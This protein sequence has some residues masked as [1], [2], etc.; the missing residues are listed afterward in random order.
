ME[1]EMTA[2]GAPDG[3]DAGPDDAT[4]PVR[5]AL[6]TVDPSFYII[7]VGASAGG[8][9]AIKQLIGQAPEG[10]PHS[11]VIIQ[12]IS[13][14]YKS[15]MSEILSRETPLPV[16]EVDDD[17]AVEPGHIYLI[18][19]KSNVV[20]Q[21]TVDDTQPETDKIGTAPALGL[22]F[23]LV[24]PVPRPQLNLPIDLFFH[25][26]AEA[27]GDRAIAI[28]LSGT[29]T[30]GSRGLR[31]IKDRDGFV[32]VQEPATANFDGMPLA[33]IATKIVDL[34]T[35]PD[36][37][38]SELQ[39][40]IAMR[41]DGVINVET[42]FKG[43]DA[44]FRE[45]LA[46]ISD[47][48]DIDFLQYKE[49]TLKR[50]IARR[51]AINHF[52]SVREYLAYARQ[53]PH[54][55]AV[56][57]REFLVGVTN[58]FR[59]LP[60]WSTLREHVIPRLFKEGEQS[61]MVKIWSVG[62]ST[63]EEAYTIAMLMESYRREHDLKRDF[64]V[65]ATDVNAD[66]IRSAK[67]GVYPESVIEE[68][69][70]EFRTADYVSFH[71]GTF[72]IAKAIRS[73]VIFTEHN[74]LEDPPYINTDLITCR[75]LLIYL[76]SD[77]QKK[78]L[79][80]FAFSMRQNGFLFL[81]AAE[82]VARQSSSFETEQGSARIYRNARK[83][84]RGMI[85][86]TV[87]QAHALTMPMPR[88]RRLA[89]RE[90]SRSNAA[91]AGVIR[92]VLDQMNGCVFVIDD[93]G[94]I[95]ETFGD[96][97]AYVGLPE[98][99]FSANIYDLVHNRL[100]SAI[101]LQMRRA[102]TEGTG[103]MK[104]IKCPVE[105][106]IDLIDVHCSRVE[107]EPHP[108]TFTLTLRRSDE[109][110]LR[111][112]DPDGA[113]R[114][115]E[116]PEG[117][118]STIARLESE[119][120][121]LQ[122]MLS[123]TA[124]DL[125]V[126]NEE[127]Q[128]TN[129]ELTVSNE[130]LQANNEE[131]Q[132]INEELHTVNAEN[133]EKIQQLE[134]ANADIENLLDTADLAIV[135]LDDE[136]LIRRY[137]TAFTRYVELTRSDIGRSLS[138]FASNIAAQD[139]PMV[140]D[141]AERARDLGHEERRDIRCK[142]GT[143]AVV[144][145][146]PYKTGDGDIF[147]VVI[148]LMDTTRQQQLQEEVRIQRDRLT[149]LLESEAAGYFDWDIPGNT[150]YLSPRFKEMFG[151][152]DDELPNTPDSWMKI[153]HPDDL[154]RVL[155]QFDEHVRTRGAVPWDNEVRYYH[156][157]GSIVWV[158][159]RGRV[160]EWGP[161]GSALRMLGVHL[162]ITALKEREKTVLRDAEEVRRFAF[163]AAHDLL[164]PMSTIERSLSSLM[165]DLSPALDE[166]QTQIMHYLGQATARMRARIN[167]VLDYARIFDG[168]V[169]FTPVDLTDL[170]QSAIDDLDSQI[171]QIG[172]EITLSPL[173]RAMAKPDLL[174]SV[175]QN[176]L[177]NAMK[178]RHPD[179]ACRIAV[180]PAPAPEGMV[181][182]RVVDNGIGIAPEFRGSVFKLFE[183]LH[184]DSDYEGIGVGLALCDRLVHLHKGTI[185]IEDGIDGGV[186][187]VCTLKAVPDA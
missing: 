96:Y 164:Q 152:A 154:P 10:F 127:L 187:F 54:E 142:D 55:L 47:K 24:A 84:Q 104:G 46:L 2:T 183:R 102:E 95:L 124:E 125:G 9:E 184:T 39:R 15:L 158:L 68:L 61:E 119:I 166:D 79:S 117:V 174:L 87:D 19:P 49:P 151:Y 111:P 91:F 32:M 163:I 8:L 136:L 99:A 22:R 172:A 171:D 141:D 66:A 123:V 80:L 145:T 144:R 17:M 51:I 23:S 48:A 155:E 13:P 45:L 71:A 40:Y 65:F 30:D 97:R 167:G 81:G 12:H 11:F 177:T 86:S 26:L 175:F 126:S 4:S 38:I 18:P 176:L 156:R 109:L 92:S 44:E 62:C 116:D 110:H 88:G 73:R 106:R 129:E 25:S 118:D 82:H 83:P 64:R 100:K 75:N 130:E 27:V 105:D 122:E 153:M 139:F 121:S 94:Q 112:S 178:Y 37:M 58:F 28:I 1:N 56:L 29:G 57:H 128:T 36:A 147:G 69:P 98:Q 7:G 20:I 35:T 67:E 149:G 140:L 70:S 169:E 131:M 135:L 90:Q 41:E 170:A 50:R 52:G 33:A 150:E 180:E 60:S 143:F 3:G 107:W 182:F 134:A 146:R 157:N 16:R 186:A 43:A 93:S 138:N 114:F 42:L 161:D 63:G 160:V 148:S 76:S 89:S 6:G 77:I 173:P 179:R 72:H 5:R 14:D 59:D 113:A 108:S 120:E 78:V 162:D 85:R 74:A 101:S 34:V 137:N 168:E 115:Q 159:C 133:A 132:S 181:G 21:G 53:R 185:A 103:E 165:E 31:A